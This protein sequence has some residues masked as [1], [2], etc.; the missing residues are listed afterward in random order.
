MSMQ[1]QIALLKGDIEH[2]AAQV[3][4]LAERIEGRR[5]ASPTT[6]NTFNEAVETLKAVRGLLMQCAMNTLKGSQQS[7]SAGYSDDDDAPF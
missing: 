3:V 6:L 2:E 4:A 5:D 1:I 7:G